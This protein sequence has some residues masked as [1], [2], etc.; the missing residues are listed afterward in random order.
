MKRI[1]QILG[2]IS[3]L[4]LS[5]CSQEELIIETTTPNQNLSE[6]V[7]AINK[8]IS[9][10]HP[11]KSRNESPNLC[12]IIHNGDTVAFLANYNDGWELFSNNTDLPMVLMRAESG[13]FYPGTFNSQ[14][15]S[16][17]ALYNEL[18]KNLTSE[19]K[20]D[21]PNPTWAIFCMPK[22]LKEDDGVDHWGFVGQAVEINSTK[23]TPKGGRLST[24]WG[25]RGNYNQHTPYVLGSI[26]N[27]HAALGCGAVA[28]GQLVYHSNKYF[29][30][31]KTT[32]NSFSYSENANWFAFSGD[33]STI[34]TKMDSGSDPNFCN[35]KEKMK[36][37]SIFLGYIANLVT[38]HFEDINDK[39]TNSK[40]ETCFWILSGQKN[41]I[42]E[43]LEYSWA[44]ILS[45]F[46]VGHPVY[47]YSS[48]HAFI[49]DYA[50]L[51]TE[52]WFD[53]YTYTNKCNDNDFGTDK[54]DKDESELDPNQMAPSKE[55]YRQKYTGDI[56]FNLV[57]SSINNRWLKMN[58]GWGGLYND[59]KIN[60][61]ASIWEING[62][63][64][65]ISRIFSYKLNR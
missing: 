29:G 16:F 50:E 54:E 27:H 18:I 9:L 42:M 20:N 10:H 56:E 63:D 37:T 28:V 61:D 51:V 36:P 22:K 35:D 30:Y 44:K 6:N 13:S 4:L 23:Y 24:Q 2:V 3:I 45:N 53:V 15:P 62:V 59:V 32:V 40:A 33:D 12:P 26:D 48:E 55:Y 41:I 5:S 47:A 11:T 25:Q 8:Y 64:L 34:W 14:N 60:A 65:T 58:W 43:Q 7:M 46:N 1:F 39:N 21:E 52:Q 49:I 31:P 19:A 57:S 17:N 38:L